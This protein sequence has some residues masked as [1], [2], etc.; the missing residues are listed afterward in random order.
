MFEVESPAGANA[1]GNN[2]LGSGPPEL[3]SRLMFTIPLGPKRELRTAVARRTS[4]GRS[5]P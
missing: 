1:A 5:S 2:A 3:V 4:A